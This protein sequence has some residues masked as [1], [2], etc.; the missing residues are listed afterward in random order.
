MEPSPPQQSE[1]KRAR[2]GNSDRQH[3]ARLELVA[4]PAP[5]PRPG[6]A[7][8]RARATWRSHEPREA[9]PAPTTGRRCRWPR[10]PRARS[11]SD[12]SLHPSR[13]RSRR[14]RRLAPPTRRP[15]CPSRSRSALPAPHVPATTQPGRTPISC[16]A[17]RASTLAPRLLRTGSSRRRNS[18][19]DRRAGWSRRQFRIAHNAYVKRSCVVSRLRSQAVNARVPVPP[20]S[21]QSVAAATFEI[22]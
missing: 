2:V 20:H 17:V 12:N 21:G 8:A 3:P 9:G 4:P 14:S 16:A 22:P 11:G 18:D 6:S 1:L 5:G 13:S 19:R 7:D 15:R 10:S